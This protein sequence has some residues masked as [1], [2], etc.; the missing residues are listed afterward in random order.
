MTV[1]GELFQ[2]NTNHPRAI[3]LNSP[4]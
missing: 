4:Q 3:H 2:A 1:P